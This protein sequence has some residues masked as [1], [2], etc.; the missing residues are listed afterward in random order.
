[1]PLFNLFKAKTTDPAPNQASFAQPVGTSGLVVTSELDKAL[2]E[3]K[4]TV[5]HIAKDCRAKNRKFRC[6][7]KLQTKLYSE[8]SHGL[9][10]DIEFDLENDKY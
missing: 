8:V 7:S 9:K 6:D 4:A 1:M 5:A 2:E 3:C 10:R